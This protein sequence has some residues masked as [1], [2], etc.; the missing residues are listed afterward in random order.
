MPLLTIVFIIAIEIGA[1]LASAPAST[2]N[3]YSASIRSLSLAMKGNIHPSTTQLGATATDA[4]GISAPWLEKLK[5]A[6]D[7]K[8]VAVRE[9]WDEEWR[10]DPNGGGFS[11]SDFCHSKSS[12]V[13]I[14]EYLLFSNSASQL[15]SQPRSL[16]YPF[17]IGSAY[18][19]ERCESHR[20]LCHGG[21]FC[22]LM[23][24]LGLATLYTKYCFIFFFLFKG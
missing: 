19:S 22:A 3:Q 20:G 7:S 21:T 13:Q 11:G 4:L 6:S 12:A 9:W 2:L 23:V 14:A 24:R 17:L 5:F 1:T 15:L 8:V 16:E 18:F 10:K